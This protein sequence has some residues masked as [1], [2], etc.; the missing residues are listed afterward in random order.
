[1]FIEVVVSLWQFFVFI[2]ALSGFIS[3]TLTNLSDQN[4]PQQKDTASAV[5]VEVA[6]ALVAHLRGSSV[7]ERN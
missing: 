5:S 2:I 1:M 7:V 6:G 3:Q 4:E